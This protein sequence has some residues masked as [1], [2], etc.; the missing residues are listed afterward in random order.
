MEEVLF[1]GTIQTG[2]VAAKRKQLMKDR[3]GAYLTDDRCKV[4]GLKQCSKVRT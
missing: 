2:W 3:S 4:K 1:S